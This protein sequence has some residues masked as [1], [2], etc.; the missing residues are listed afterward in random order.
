MLISQINQILRK[1]YEEY[2]KNCSNHSADGTVSSTAV[3]TYTGGYLTK[4]VVTGTTSAGTCSASNNGSGS[5]TLEYSNFSGKNPQTRKCTP[6]TTT[7]DTIS[8]V[9]TYEGGQVKTQA[10]TNTVTTT[11]NAYISYTYSGSVLTD[12]K[13]FSGATTADSTKLIFGIETV[14]NGTTITATTSTYTAGASKTKFATTDYTITS[15][16]VTRVLTT[17]FTSGAVTSSTLD[18]YAYTSST[19]FTKKSYSATGTTVVSESS[20]LS[21]SSANTYS[22]GLLTKIENFNTSTGAS[23]SNTAVTYVGSIPST[24]IFTNSVTSTSST[25]AAYVFTDSTKTITITTDSGTT[26]C[27]GGSGKS[28]KTITHNG[29]SNTNFNGFRDNTD[30]SL[31]QA[32][33]INYVGDPVIRA[34]ENQKLF[35]FLGL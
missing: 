35:A 18:V 30:R 15:G 9:L 25:C 21:S 16:Q 4:S 11:N 23:S 28:V 14:D 2:S 8:D 6:G 1:K 27:S 31:E 3:N 19:G 34:G 32:G 33:K 13:Y 10:T 22:G 17:N 5:Y 24:V 26:T 12:Y 20:T 29:F 7:S